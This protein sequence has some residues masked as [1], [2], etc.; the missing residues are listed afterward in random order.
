MRLLK[1]L[2]IVVFLLPV[3]AFAQSP[4]ASDDSAVLKNIYTKLTDFSTDH[5][6]ERAY[7]QFDKPYYAAGDTIWFKAFVTLGDKHKLSDR[8]GILHIDLIDANNRVNQF[9]KLQLINGV[10]WGDFSLPDTLAAGN[11][12]VRVYTQWMRNS[13]DDSFF[14]NYIPIGAAKRK[15]NVGGVVKQ[16]M[17][18]PKQVA[19]TAIAQLPAKPDTHFFPEG[20]SLVA[21]M[22]SK[23]AFKAIGTDGL[24]IDVKGVI[25]DNDNKEIFSFA[26]AHLGMGFFYLDAE[27]DK[28]YKAKLTY[29]NGTTD[30][31]ELPKPDIKG[32]IL[33]IN[34]S[35]KFSAIRVKANKAFYTENKAKSFT[36]FIYSGGSTISAIFKLDKPNFG[37]N[38]YK[39]QLHSGITR[40][41]VFSSTGEPLNERLVF[42]QNN[43]QLKLQV[44]TDKPQYAKREKTSLKLNATD[45]DGNGAQGHFSVAIIDQG[46]VPSNEN[47]ASTI[48]TNLLLTS[49]LAGYIEQPN[50]YFANN[51]AATISDLDMVMLTHGYR[52]FEWKQLLAGGYPAARY[53]PENT[54]EITGTAKTMA[55]QPLINGNITLASFRNNVFLTQTT[56]AE[57]HFRFPNLAFNDTIHF[58]LNAMNAK[59]KSET[60]LTYSVEKPLPP[61]IH[62]YNIPYRDTLAAY[63]QNRQKQLDDEAMYGSA[64][65]K[66]LKEVKV[67]ENKK[68]D[69]SEYR[70]SG[71]AGP[72]HADKVLHSADFAH[73]GGNIVFVLEAKFPE[74]TFKRND[75]FG[76]PDIPLLTSAQV[77]QSIKP[78][79]SKK[80]LGVTVPAD[81]PTIGMM[82]IVDGVALPDGS[83]I[84]FIDA[85]IIETVEL[86]EYSNTAIY[87]ARGAGGVLIFNTKKGPGQSKD[88]S[89]TNIL[90]IIATGF[91]KAREFYVPKYDHP[92]T[93]TREDLRS[94]IYWKSELL[95][96]KSGNATIDFPN[97]DGTGNYL[98]TIEGIDDKGNIGRTTYT[99]KVQ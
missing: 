49:D 12:R 19:P 88:I 8:G 72:G 35:V 7:L 77:A 63:L 6:A 81:P 99:Y 91:Y 54:L 98:V 62:N 53:Q 78:G 93:S 73:A 74:L 31:V 82:I 69:E 40:V 96:D 21:G 80:T 30:V 9:I 46:K 95:T 79:V 59:G 58:V 97:A 23:V 26:S 64:N 55:D 42:I 25:T 36:L 18:S 20:G 39:N 65:G 47:A 67:N 48:Y 76:T 43:D 14:E 16:P 68:S 86:L 32:M 38:I 85:D 44:S 3:G 4:V 61:F 87:G 50:Y 83:G 41:A 37:L 13:G 10:A 1:I 24:G 2:L 28:T 56:D 89:G 84:S 17:Q 70:S 34:D 90:P 51:A 57:G 27:D 11:Y 5:K 94:T 60:K 45:K 92:A 15:A 29:P 33:A 22:R 75:R 71:L 66:L 52:R